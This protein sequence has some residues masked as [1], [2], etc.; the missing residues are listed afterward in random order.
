LTQYEYGSKGGDK[1]FEEQVLHHLDHPSPDH[2][3][4]ID[5]PKQPLR[6][7][8]GNPSA[9]SDPIGMMREVMTGH[10]VDF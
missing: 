9:V 7:L 8:G 2:V 4:F 5:K 10:G 3:V 1:A 6:D